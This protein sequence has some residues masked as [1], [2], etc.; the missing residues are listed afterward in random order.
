MLC[1]YENKYKNLVFSDI[2][3]CLF[4][5]IYLGIL[6]K[7]KNNIFYLIVILLIIG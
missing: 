5:E 6:L 3:C 7:K 4:K 2:F 1:E